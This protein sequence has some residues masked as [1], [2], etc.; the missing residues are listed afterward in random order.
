M[1]GLKN[2]I[3]DPY[4]VVSPMPYIFP[5]LDHYLPVLAATA[6]FMICLLEYTLE[7]ANKAL[8]EQFF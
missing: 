3:L 1:H 2:S 5:A 6:M 8:L 7:W 4:F